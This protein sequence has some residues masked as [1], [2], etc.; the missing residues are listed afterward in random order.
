M[1]GLQRLGFEIKAVLGIGYEADGDRVVFIDEKG[2][3]IPGDYSGALIAKYAD[4]QAVVT[5]INTSQ[6]VEHIGKKVIRTKV[7]SPYVVKAMKDK[8]IPFGFEGN[9]GGVSSE[10][11][12]RHRL[13]QPR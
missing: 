6:V 9:G 11:M 1:P 2:Q 8:N 12:I 7:G 10:I 5:P 4:G 13:Q 3:F